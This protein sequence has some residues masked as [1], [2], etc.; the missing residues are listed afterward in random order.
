MRSR[1]LDWCYWNPPAMLASLPRRLAALLV[2]SVLTGLLAGCVDPTVKEW[3]RL[4]H[5]LVEQDRDR[6][7]RARDTE[8]ALT[9]GIEITFLSRRTAEAIRQSSRAICHARDWR[10][11][12][13][14]TGVDCYRMGGLVSVDI[15]PLSDGLVAVT[16]KASGD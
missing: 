5:S 8:N 10:S 11:G 14:P 1:R 7:L 12:V 3:V 6:D 2:V 16:V 13:T 4:A 15:R 9:G